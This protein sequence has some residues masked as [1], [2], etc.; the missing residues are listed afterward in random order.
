MIQPP[1]LD[2]LKGVQRAGKGWLAFC[3]AHDDKAKRSL[4]V[5]IG[6]DS[7]TLLK[8]HARGCTVEQITAAVSMTLATLAP[9]SSSSGHRRSSPP[10]IVATYDYTDERGEL[11]Y[12]VVRQEPKDFRCRRPDGT[13]GWTWSLDGVPVVP[14]RLHELAEADRVFVAEGEKDVDTLASVGLV[15]TC[16]H[17]GAGKWREEHTHALVAAAVPE[18]VVLRDAD[19][20]GGAHQRSV[21]TSCATGGLAIVKVLDLPDLAAKGDVSDYVAAQRAA[22]RTDEEIR[23]ALLALAD[24]APVFTLETLKSASTLPDYIET[25]ADFLGEDDP[26][27]EVI[28]PELLPRGVIMLI[29]GEARARKS[30]AAFEL[31]LSAATGSAPFGLERFRAATPV[32][33]LYIQEEDPRPLTR[34]RLRHLVQERCGHTTPTTLHVSVRRGVDLD[35]PAWVSRLIADLKRL[36]V[37]LLVLDA[38]RRFSA[39][40]DEG[41]A[42]V[43]ELTAVLRSI[44]TTAGVT[45]AIVHHDVKPPQNGQDQRRRSQRASG[46]DWFAACECPVHVER[47]NESE[48]LVYPQDYKFSADPTPFTFRIDVD[49]GFVRRLV[50]VDTSTDQAERAGVRGKVLDW[51]RANGPA[52]RTDIKQAGIAQWPAI[53]TALNDLMKDGKADAT[54][55][56]KA[57]SLRYFAIGEPSTANSD[58]SAAGGQE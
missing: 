18:V 49:G 11:L 28:F 55:G 6:D 34:P 44:V 57:G 20:A 39:K 12:Q 45:L 17:G 3:P 41:P 47:V 43:R 53:E 21:A 10:L 4:S 16:N 5:G 42:K 1:I 2:R 38:A 51:L 9:T 24:K 32:T 54:P 14:Y 46:G 56:R 30:L 31:A 8:C 33:V 7:R 37:R 25:I 23:V 13:G 52:T 22:G 58:G 15:A 48:S 29:H 26:P 40:T 19:A 27:V 36:G 35:D 50:G